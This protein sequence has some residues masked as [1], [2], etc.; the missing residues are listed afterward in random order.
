M[1]MSANKTYTVDNIEFWG[2]IYQTGKLPWD[3]GGP[4]PPLKTFL[5]SPY[6]VPPAS[7]AI[8]GCGTGHDC[9]LFANHGFQVTGIDFAPLA[10]Q[11]THQK[12]IDAGIAGTSGFLL[13][14]NLFDLDEYDG[15]FDYVLEHAMFNS[16]EP[17]RRR[18]YVHAVYDLLKPGGKLIAL[19]WVLDRPGGPPFGIAKDALFSLFGQFF[20]FDIVHTPTDSAPGRQGHELFTLM[21]KK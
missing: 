9:L 20:S 17:T 1:V 14:R 18:S 6:K 7:I 13:Q 21:T 2:Q 3:L 5:K 12:F 10:I 16:I 8:P 15:Y 19:W 11:A 4:A